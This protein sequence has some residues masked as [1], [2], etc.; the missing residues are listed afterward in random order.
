MTLTLENYRDLDWTSEVIA[1]D[2]FAFF[3]KLTFEQRVELLKFLLEKFPEYDDEWI[4]YYFEISDKWI[5]NGQWDKIAEFA[6]FIREKSPKSYE[7]EGKYLSETPTAHALFH[8]DLDKAKLS[9]AYSIE[10]PEATIDDSLR[11]GFNILSTYPKFKN[12]TKDAAQK[13]WQPLAQSE[14]LIGGAE[15]N[16]SAYLYCDFLEDAFDT[17]KSGGV[18]D[19]EKFTQDVEA[20]NFKYVEEFSLLP[21]L[22]ITFDE[23]QFNK[24]ENY[25]NKKLNKI[26]VP[27]LY[28]A[29]TEMGIPVY[30]AFRTWFEWRKY[31]VEADDAP[32]RSNWL[33][34][35][36]KMLDKMGGK[37]YGFFG[38][39]RT[40]MFISMWTLPYLYDFF[41]QQNYIDTPFYTRLMEYYQYIRRELLNTFRQTL[42]KYK[43]LYS[44][45]KPNF[46]SDSAFKAEEQLM[47]ASINWNAV[48]AKKE[49]AAYR[50]SLPSLPKYVV[51][52][53]PEPSPYE[54]MLK[55]GFGKTGDFMTPK[56]KKDTSRPKKKRK[57]KHKDNRKQGK[58]K[59]R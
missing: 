11:S 52:P 38:E 59:R 48:D 51:P 35:T 54:R 45:S 31:L 12:Y 6:D 49:V 44:W 56:P 55:S 5:A 47:Q 29:H 40:G 32:K 23:E 8:D 3:K 57:K 41:H 36:P 4:Q 2:Y 25:R 19:W 50:E 28:A 46:L 30:W 33:V 17:I 13:V 34:F 37:M 27:F 22:T 14:I 10:H 53:P 16:Y 20:I 39:N 15:F 9:F 42:W 24:S 43:G 26:L 1:D 18:V 21:N 7:K 58:K